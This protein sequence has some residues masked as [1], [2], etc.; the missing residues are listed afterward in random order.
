MC[1]RPLA[2]WHTVTHTQRSRVCDSVLCAQ[3]LCFASVCASQCALLCFSC[4][5]AFVLSRACS[6][7]SDKISSPALLPR[8]SLHMEHAS[9]RRAGRTNRHRLTL[10]SR[11]W[12]VIQIHIRNTY[13]KYTNTLW[14]QVPGRWYTSAPAP[15]KLWFNSKKILWSLSRLNWTQHLFWSLSVKTKTKRCRNLQKWS[16]NPI[17]SGWKSSGK[18][19]F[20]STDAAGQHLH[21]FQIVLQTTW[22]A[23]GWC[24]S[25]P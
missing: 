18:T 1:W 17:R 24:W 12:S 10:A 23:D 11:S 2:A 6:L 22:S 16:N 5:C 7:W 13:Y 15:H 8:R 20:W 25:F 14:P 19:M 9:L 4:T 21:W 3:L